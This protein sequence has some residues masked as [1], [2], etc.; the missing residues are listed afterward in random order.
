MWVAITQLDQIGTAVLD[1][2]TQTPK[3]FIYI[4]FFVRK[5]TKGLSLRHKLKYKPKFK[6]KLRLDYLI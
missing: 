1:T 5:V 4:L 3:L 6:F 2:N